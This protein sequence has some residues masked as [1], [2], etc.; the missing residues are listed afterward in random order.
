ML[1]TFTPDYP[2]GQRSL[3]PFSPNESGA[4]Y[5]S[6]ALDIVEDGFL[7]KRSQLFNMASTV[8]ASFPIG[9]VKSRLGLEFYVWFL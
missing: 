3:C 8:S 9:C 7:W 2:T 1:I 5:S 4:V 6:I